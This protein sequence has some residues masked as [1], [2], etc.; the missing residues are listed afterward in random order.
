MRRAGKID[1]NQPEIVRDLRLLGYSVWITSA[2]G[3]GGPDLIV[4]KGKRCIPVE[5][6]DP[7]QPPSKRQLNDRERAWHAAW[8]GPVV[9]AERTEDVL[10]ALASL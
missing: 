6:K 3:D 5:V 7:L 1:R 10:K 8:G 9:I 4:G 2:L